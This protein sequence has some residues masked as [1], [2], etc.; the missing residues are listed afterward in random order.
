MEEKS[1]SRLLKGDM[2][3]SGIRDIIP[4]ESDPIMEEVTPPPYVLA[5]L[6]AI[7]ESVRAVDAATSACSALPR[8]VAVREMAMSAF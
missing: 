5:V 4:M 6:K 1:E 7:T 3:E 2:L 8:A